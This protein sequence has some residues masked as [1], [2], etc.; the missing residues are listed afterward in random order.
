MQICS[1]VISSLR[2]SS[3]GMKN[4]SFKTKKEDSSSIFQY[5]CTSNIFARRTY[6]GLCP[7]VFT[8]LFTL[9]LA[10]QSKMSVVCA[11]CYLDAPG[12]LRG[13]HCLD[14]EHVHYAESI[15]YFITPQVGR[16]IKSLALV[17]DNSI[18]EG[19]WWWGGEGG[20]QSK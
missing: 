1:R 18:W 14:V 4:P 13:V 17:S 9:A 2:T 8:V 19:G 5:N 3:L 16:S 10:K 11:S 6:F 15:L 12:M 7:A 20:R